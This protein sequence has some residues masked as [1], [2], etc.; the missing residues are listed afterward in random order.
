MPF[1]SKLISPVSDGILLSIVR[2]ALGPSAQIENRTLLK[3]GKFNTTYRIGTL[4]AERDLVIRLAPVRQELLYRF[5]RSLQR[6]ETQI[7]GLLESRGVPVPKVIR[8]DDSREIV[9]RE[10]IITEYIESIPLEDANLSGNAYQDV[11]RSLG[12]F[13]RLIHSI[14]GEGFGWF[15]MSRASGLAGTWHGFLSEFVEEIASRSDRFGV[16]P[17][18]HVR[19]V[20]SI[21]GQGPALFPDPRPIALLHNDLHPGNILMRK[22]GNAFEIA[23]L[24]DAD[25]ALFGDPDFEFATSGLID[26]GF[27]D[28]YGRPLDPSP[29]AVFRRKMYSLTWNMLD[30]DACMTQIGNARAYE[31]LEKCIET[32]CESL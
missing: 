4:G 17:M 26:G 10:Y 25:R 21:L 29:E 3:G 9:D 30:A 18:K 28:G 16:T 11:M 8:H 22:G 15:G 27:M 1:E 2:R 24:I 13:A 7:Y 32:E 20:Q 14:S 23:A 12:A 5:E 6:A 31:I 19:K